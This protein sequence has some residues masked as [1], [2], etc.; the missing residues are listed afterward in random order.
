METEHEVQRRRKKRKSKKKKG[1]KIALG[2]IVLLILGV[3]IYGYSVYSS[4]A[5]TFNRTHEPLSREKSD[6]RSEKV[7]LAKHDPISILLLGVDQRGA[8]RGRSDSLML[9]TVNPDKK[10][11]KMVSIPRDTRTEIVGKGKEDKI[12]HAYAFGGVDM[13]I[14]T[15]E[16]FLNV[17][18]DY[19]IQ[20]NMESFKD[21][22]DAVGGV[23]VN[24]TLDF[25]Y[26]GHHF[27]KGQL[28]LNGE[29]ALSYSRMRYDDPRGDFGRQSRQ[30]QIIQA[31]IDEGASI[32]SLTNYGTILDAIGDNVKTNLTFDDMK[33]IQS[34]YKEAR[35]NVEHIQ[36]NGTGGKMNGIYYYNVPESERTKI[37]NT[38]KENLNLN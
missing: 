24:N 5:N 26:E 27:E 17:P 34:N 3:G 7:S 36:I 11:V 31:V 28:K 35:N 18:I 38:L 33:E 20:V 22:V 32:K 29:K 37:S 15:V 12:N 30:Q 8:D 6:K 25:T 1:F 23:T 13:S 16:N 9:L 10:A 4:V 21:I 2:I 19:Y 14:K